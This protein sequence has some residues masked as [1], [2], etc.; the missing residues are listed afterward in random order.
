M[1]STT[2][3]G[4]DGT[5]EVTFKVTVNEIKSK[6]IPELNKDFFAEGRE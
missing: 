1:L 4:K 5:A 3:S 6:V 2:A